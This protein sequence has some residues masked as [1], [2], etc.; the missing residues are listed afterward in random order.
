MLNQFVLSYLKNSV[1]LIYIKSTLYID[2][3]YN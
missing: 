2:K 1:D 3:V